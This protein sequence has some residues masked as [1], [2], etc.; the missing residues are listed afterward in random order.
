ME[1]QE[2]EIRL[3]GLRQVKEQTRLYRWD[4]MKFQGEKV[5]V[6]LSTDFEQDNAA[7]T[8]TVRIT[9]RYTALR[10]QIRRRLLDYTAEATFAISRIDGLIDVADDEMLVSIDLLRLMLGISVGSLRGM[11]AAFTEGTALE[12]Y[13]LPLYDL[14]ALVANIVRAGKPV[15]DAR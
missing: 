2:L 6:A 9:A 10:G 15:S 11:I 12:P 8:V 14:H 5:D 1:E 3:T 13:P 4:L 7:R